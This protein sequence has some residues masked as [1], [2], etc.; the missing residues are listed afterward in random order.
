M[1]LVLEKSQLMPGDLRSILITDKTV[2]EN[3]FLLTRLCLQSGS[4]FVMTRDRS[5]CHRE[6]LRTFNRVENC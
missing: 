1:R 5:C 6:S 2:S 3:R 4:I